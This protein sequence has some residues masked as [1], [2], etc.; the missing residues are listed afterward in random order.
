MDMNMDMQQER[1]NEGQDRA[2]KG[3]EG[4]NQESHFSKIQILN[5][6]LHHSKGIRTLE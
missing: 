3:R 2:G 6:C 5:H 1:Q 4:R